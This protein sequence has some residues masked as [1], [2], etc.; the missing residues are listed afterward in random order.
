MQVLHTFLSEQWA[1]NFKVTL[2]AL[3]NP[4]TRGGPPSM[5]SLHNDCR[6]T[7]V[8]PVRGFVELPGIR[9]K[10]QRPP[11]TVNM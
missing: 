9:L 5:F 11:K 7:S 10:I 3:T 1:S 8:G 6:S 4:A 2:N